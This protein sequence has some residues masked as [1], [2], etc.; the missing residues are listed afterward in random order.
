[1]WTKLAH[2][3]I[4][5]RLP[6]III[7]VLVTIFMGYRARNVELDY[8]LA[9][10]VPETDEDYK[11][12]KEFERKFGVDDNVLALGIK[13]STLYTPQNFARL[14]YFSKALKDVNG[15]NNVLSIADLQE[16]KK[17]NEKRKFEMQPLIK[18]L[19]QNQAGLDS[20]LK[21]IENQ[22][23]FS[24]QLLNAE[25]GA[26]AVIIT[27]D[28]NVFNSP[29]RERL[30][31]DITQLGDAFE[32]KT[33]IELHYAGLPFVRSTM[34][35]KVRQEIIQLLVLSVIVTALILLA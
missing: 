17:N 32:E 12:L 25:N 10:L 29:D 5:Y 14:Q 21:E 23:F 30:M 4:K 28:E 8:D 1:M 31:S 3:V 34:M 22:K 15:V 20:L 13:D 6:L 2:N 19:P 18:D 16:L 27:L 11:A 33:D 35:S 26:T 24:S 7:L 9:K